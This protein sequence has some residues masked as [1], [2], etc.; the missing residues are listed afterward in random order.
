M[1]SFCCTVTGA[2]T[3][4]DGQEDFFG[5]FGRVD[6]DD[7]FDDFFGRPGV[8]PDP[9]PDTPGAAAPPTAKKRA[10]KAKPKTPRGKSGGTNTDDG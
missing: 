7:F 5:E 6:F 9:D 1:F 10:T 4:P 2:P 3:R 8:D